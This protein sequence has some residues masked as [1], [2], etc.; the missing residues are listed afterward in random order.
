LSIQIISLAYCENT[1]KC[2]L[3]AKWLKDVSCI[4]G[5]LPALE[6]T[7]SRAFSYLPSLEPLPLFR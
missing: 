1:D 6:Q 3:I 2:I 4:S 7:F 5:V